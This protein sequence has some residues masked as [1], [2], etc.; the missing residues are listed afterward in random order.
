MIYWTCWLMLQRLMNKLA[1][2]II[3]GSSCKHHLINKLFLSHKWHAF[4]LEAS[5]KSSKNSKRLA[6]HCKW[7]D[8]DK[9][10]CLPH[11][12]NVQNIDHSSI[13]FYLWLKFRYK[14]RFYWIMNFSGP[15]FSGPNF[16]MT[17]GVSGVNV[18]MKPEVN[19]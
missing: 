12:I 7:K 3:Y 1:L 15:E 19:F 14:I 8:R 17:F 6:I 10:L 11:L 18:C 4:I 16:E 5:Q 9:I 2:Y 13:R